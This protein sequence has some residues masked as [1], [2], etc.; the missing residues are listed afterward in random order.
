MSEA[1]IFANSNLFDAVQVIETNEKRI[2]IVLD[3]NG[4]L[5]GTLTDGDIRR[6]LLNNG[7]L[8]ASVVSAMNPNPVKA[9]VNSSKSYILD[10]MKTNNIR[11]VPLVGP[12]DTFMRVVEIKELVSKDIQEPPFNGFEVAVIMAGGEGMRL[13][14]ITETIPKPMVK[15]DGIP[16]LERQIHRLKKIGV[17][18]IYLSVNYL[19]KVIENHFGDG[20]KFGIEI[21]YL[22]ENRKLGTAGAL[23]L[24]KENFNKPILVMNGDILTTS[25]F[26]NLYN[27]H[28]DHD[29]CITAAAIH[30]LVDIPYGVFEASQAIVHRIDE[31]PSQQ[32]LCNAGIYAVSPEIVADLCDETALSMPDLIEKCLQENK[33]VVVFPVHEYWTD[34]GTPEDLDKAQEDFFNIAKHYD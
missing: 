26:N 4:K 12:R 2:A 16:L 33:T 21:S 25:D 8:D 7:S 6:H 32:F 27:F 9:D 18:R 5:V 30:Y 31:K 11:A 14:P 15:I 13:R 10:L 3:Q 1:V 34:I 17:S 22:K 24:L 23:Y 20:K 29:A 19:S 28:F